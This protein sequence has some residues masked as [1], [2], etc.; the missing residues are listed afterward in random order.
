MSDVTL[1]SVYQHAD[2]ERILYALLR[3][4]AVEPDDYVPAAERRLPPYAEHVK[5]V[6]AK[7]FRYWYLIKAEEKVVGYVSVSRTNEIGVVLF[8]ENRK[9]GYGV[10]A[11]GAI[12]ER[13]KPLAEIKGKRA[14]RFLA[15]IHPQNEASVKLFHRLGFTLSYQVYEL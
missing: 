11:V 8:R 14:G 6:K 15:K 10:A 12:T 2:S 5:F 3:E 4:R 1:V 13:H 7:P 9:R